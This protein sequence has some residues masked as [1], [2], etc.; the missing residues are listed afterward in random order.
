MNLK[1]YSAQT[2]VKKAN[3]ARSVGVSPALLHQ[4]IEG[5]RP[6]AIRHCLAI[7]RA[8][9]GQ[10]TRKDLRPD[11][12]QNIWP[13]LAPSCTTTAPAAVTPLNRTGEAA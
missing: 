8:T 9:D 10:V 2:E 4:W 12:W 6:V 1:N 13:E 3:L 11:D 7:E 5:I